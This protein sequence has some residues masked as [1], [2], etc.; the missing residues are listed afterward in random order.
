MA[1]LQTELWVRRVPTAENIAD[2]PSRE[3][4]DLLAKLKAQRVEARLDPVFERPTTWKALS[5]LGVL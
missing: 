4:Y 5:I 2:H 1:S 3:H